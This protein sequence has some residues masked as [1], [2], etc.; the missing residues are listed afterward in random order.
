ML[1]R[2]RLQYLWSI[3]L[4]VSSGVVLSILLSDVTGIE[5]GMEKRLHSLQMIPNSEVVFSSLMGY[6]AFIF[7]S[8]FIPSLISLIVLLKKNKNASLISLC[9]GFILLIWIIFELLVFG[10]NNITNIFLLLC[11]A[12]CLTSSNV[13]IHKEK[14][15]EA[16]EIN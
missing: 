13:I 8:V 4:I 1:F 2:S 7:V 15:T 9:C 14:I 16:F 5:T 10:F 6:A 12:Q 11:M 3:L